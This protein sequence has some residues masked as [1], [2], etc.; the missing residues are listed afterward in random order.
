MFGF[1]SYSERPFSAIEPII[2]AVTTSIFAD[3]AINIE[4]RLG[5]LS[6]A[7]QEGLMNDIVAYWKLDE[8][9]SYAP[10]LDSYS[11]GYHLT[12]YNSVGSVAGIFGAASTFYHL[13]SEYLYRSHDSIFNPTDAFS[14]AGW[15]RFDKDIPYN[16]RTIFSK[17]DTGSENWSLRMHGPHP[18]R[19]VGFYL[20]NGSSSAEAIIGS[21]LAHST[22]YYAIAG[23]DSLA[24]LLWLKIYNTSGGLEHDVTTPYTGGGNASNSSRLIM[25]AR[26]AGA[27]TTNHWFGDIDEVGFWNKK[28]TTRDIS[29]LVNGG[30]YRTFPFNGHEGIQ[31]D[32]LQLTPSSQVIYLSWR[33]L[34][35]LDGN[36]YIDSTFPV[37]NK[38]GTK[39]DPEIPIEYFVKGLIAEATSSASF[40]HDTGEDTETS[41]V[42]LSGIGPDLELNTDWRTPA[43]LNGVLDIEWALDFGVEID[44]YIGFLKDS[45]A[46]SSLATEIIETFKHDDI[47]PISFG[48]T[49]L[50]SSILKWT[51]INDKNLWTL[52][53]DQNTWTL[54][55]GSSSASS[56]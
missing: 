19:K 53:N 33:I 32:F 54:I 12:N 52:K 50:V 27:A 34:V 7:T 15:F 55:K 26:S 25:G 29:E 9:N 48:G 21:S 13:S 49:E 38:I 31:V 18:D 8:N 35:D 20:S 17:T 23:W 46:D 42:F 39:I 10:R 22:W 14:I 51:L 16:T 41:V 37:S 45:G 24:G 30:S 43:V 4:N 11:G 47:I 5:I 44:T 36:P 2:G 28:L 1:H 3:E 40:L 6:P 56:N